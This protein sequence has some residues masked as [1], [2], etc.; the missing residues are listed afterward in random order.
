MSSDYSINITLDTLYSE[1]N[2]MRILNQGILVG[3]KYHDPEDDQIIIQPEQAI[4]I[5]F[6]NLYE[7]ESPAVYTT[8]EKIGTFFIWFFKSDDN[9]LIFSMG[10][11]GDPIRKDFL[12]S[13]RAIDWAIY[14]R[15]AL[16]IVENFA[17]T[18]IEIET[19]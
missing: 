19:I 1:E 13:I 17:I 18:K 11:F 3:L 2:M 9:S 5:V 12:Y 10:G 15:H 6:K 14:I 16:S 8:E 7:G 4:K